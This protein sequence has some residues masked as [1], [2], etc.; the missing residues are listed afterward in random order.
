M[1]TNLSK[2][3][4]VDV[5]VT[6]RFLRTA[7]LNDEFYVP[8]TDPATFLVR[9]KAAGVCAD[10]FTF[11]Q[12]L[13][14]GPYRYGYY[15]ALE[16]MAVLS[17]TTFDNWMNK[18]IRCKPRNM[19]RKAL[20]NGV[21]IRVVEFSDELLCGIKEIYN[22]TPIRQ[23]KRNWHYG[24]S[25]EVLRKEHATF[26]D[27]SEFVG[28]YLDS[29]LIGFAKVTHS[30][31]YSII[32]NIMAKVSQ[33][34]NAPTNALLAKVVELVTAREIPLLNFGIWGRSGLNQFK[35]A[36]GF[37]RLDVPRYYIPLTLKGQLALQLGL[38]RSLKDRLPESWIIT[39]KNAR[40][41]WSERKYGN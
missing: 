39:A 5:K 32:M 41:K 34:N 38:H 13:H 10:L 26:L 11:V 30:E 33:R 29:E 25:I 15:H 3:D 22:E 7:Q 28:A 36:S 27:R 23:G 35:V 19:I 37:Q 31:H 4:N 18:Q 40:A 2:V 21:K 12:E 16:A 6:G 24:K 1:Q 20:K 9:L 14:D 17:L 8:V